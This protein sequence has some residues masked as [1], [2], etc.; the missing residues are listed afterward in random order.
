MEG[1]N[2]TDDGDMTKVPLRDIFRP[3][4]ILA[5]I[6]VISLLLS[7]PIYERNHAGEKTGARQE[8][9]IPRPNLVTRTDG[10][11]IFKVPKD[12]KGNFYFYLDRNHDY[13]FDVS[14]EGNNRDGIDFITKK[15]DLVNGPTLSDLINSYNG[16]IMDLTPSGAFGSRKGGSQ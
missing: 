12:N 7:G 11:M 13:R 14:G 15:Y 2:P 16:S 8:I 6:G 4:G 3:F 9:N 10:S 5:G 1:G